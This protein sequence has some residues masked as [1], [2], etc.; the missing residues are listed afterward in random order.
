MQVR[1]VVIVVAILLSLAVSLPAASTAEPDT[2][3]NFGS[4][5]A[6][7]RPSDFPVASLMRADCAFV[8]RVE[9]PD[10][11]AIATGPLTSVTSAPRAASAEAMAW[12]CLP[13]EWLEM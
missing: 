4:V 1:A 11:S 9:R 5:V 12:P 3:T 13:E 8:Q 6:V 7:A 2:V 10:G